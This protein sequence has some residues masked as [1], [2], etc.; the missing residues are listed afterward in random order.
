LH[1]AAK[2]IARRLASDYGRNIEAQIIVPGAI[3][4]AGKRFEVAKDFS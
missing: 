4:A 1:E 2:M 3:I